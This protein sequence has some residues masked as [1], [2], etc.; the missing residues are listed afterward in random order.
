MFLWVLLAKKKTKKNQELESQQGEKRACSNS[1]ER[2][3]WPIHF[4]KINQ[5]ASNSNL[6]VKLVNSFIP[7]ERPGF[8]D[9]FTG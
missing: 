8:T 7:N 3:K 9:S 4:S 1:S 6:N 2:S 5:P